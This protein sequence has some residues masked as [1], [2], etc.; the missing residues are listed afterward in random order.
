VATNPKPKNGFFIGVGC[1]GCGGALSLDADFFV[2]RCDHCNSVL[3][4]VMPD[5]PPAYLIPCKVADRAIRNHIDRYL[6]QNNLP[7]TGSSLH[8]KK[9]YY[10]Y[11]RSQASVLKLRNKTEIKKLYSDSE[12]QTE[13]VIETD[14]ST[15]ST[16]PYLLTVAAGA[17]VDGVPDTLGL[18]SETV[19]VVPFSDESF[20]PEF[21]VL[22]VTRSWQNVEQRVR[23]AVAALSQI[24][25]PDFGMNITKLFNPSWSLVYFPYLIVEAYSGGYRRFVLDGLVGRV[26]KSV[27]PEADQTGER[28]QDKVDHKIKVGRINLTFETGAAPQRLHENFVADA[29]SRG[30]ADDLMQIET[31]AD[32]TDG[33]TP[34]LSFGHLDVVFHRCDVCGADLP[35][36]QS[37]VYL[38]PN[39]HELQ[40]VG[41]MDYRLSQI[42]V[43]TFGEAPVT[44]LVPFWR[45]GLLELA[46][47][48]LGNLFGGFQRCDSLLIPAMGTKNL[49]ALHKL[50]KRMSTAQ[51]KMPTK[52][53]ES[54]DERFLPVRIGL[55]EALALAEIIISR[56]LLDKGL[57][58]PNSLDLKP[59]S[60]GLVYIPF[61]LEIYFYVDSVLN[62]VSMEKALV[63]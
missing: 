29:L 5:T 16:S 54:L 57:G 18:R 2:T 63:S 38:C 35:A 31:E 25:T 11:W 43:A 30:V 13:T 24:D 48:R 55:T 7:L 21:D 8:V 53:V 17:P 32:N 41:R 3:R 10:P 6:K 60:V 1:P 44:H 58:L 36:E 39:C 50:T 59:T 46:T 23:L 15:V 14:R 40:V 33:V 37:H 19:R 26:V 47:N 45:L 52:A 62:A 34:D 61:H 28:S 51:G 4:I 20:A 9:L 27:E 22:P 56:E 12:S 49:D 42:D